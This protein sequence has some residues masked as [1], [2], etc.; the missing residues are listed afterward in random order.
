V[1]ED[2][3]SRLPRNSLSRK[4][5]YMDFHTKLAQSILCTLLIIVL[6]ALNQ[7]GSWSKHSLK[8]VLGVVGRE[9]GE[10]LMADEDGT[11]M[12]QRWGRDGKETGERWDE[13][14]SKRPCCQERMILAEYG[15][16]LELRKWLRICNVTCGRGHSNLPSYQIS[17]LRR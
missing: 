17:L 13:V 1:V 14:Q 15:V 12:G 11:E 6:L 10:R 4:T 3:K 16:R 5:E 8:D 9:L 7:R 2:P